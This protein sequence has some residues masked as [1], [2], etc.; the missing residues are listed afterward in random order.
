MNRK[1]LFYSIDSSAE[2]IFEF[3]KNRVKNP[4]IIKN[5][6]IIVF[7]FNNHPPSEGSLSQLK[8]GIYTIPFS[9]SNVWS[10]IV[11]VLPVQLRTAKQLLYS[12][13]KNKYES[14]PNP[15]TNMN[16]T[17]FR[18]YRSEIEDI[19]LEILNNTNKKRKEGV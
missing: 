3:I 4:I 1:K 19:V 11:S 18:K 16:E 17:T 14:A 2:E 13:K 5:G 10:Y 12:V 9:L 6:A 8:K 15:F 7:D